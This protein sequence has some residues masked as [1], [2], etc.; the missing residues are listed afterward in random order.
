M[1]IRLTENEIRFFRDNGFV[2]KRKVLRP[3]LI[4]KAQEVFWSHAP[5]QLERDNPAS[6]IGPFREEHHQNEGG[7]MNYRGGFRW[8]LRSI[9]QE[10]W[11]MDLIP[12]D[13]NMIAIAE[14]LLGAGQLQPP[15]RV[16][17]IYSTLPMTGE[18]PVGD[19]MHVDEHP[20]HLGIV[21]YLGTVGPNGG[22]FRVWPTSHRW[23]YPIF[24]SQYKSAR[25]EA[26]NEL[27][28]FFET[29]PT[30]D[31]TG[32]AGDV[33]LWHHRLAHTAGRNYS[34][35]IRQAVLYDFC[36]A[37]IGITQEEPPQKDMWRDWPGCR[38]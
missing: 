18:P 13:A 31:C 21:G 20:F 4:A 9:C 38:I 1:S 29:Q 7:G 10:D 6:W 36:K 30:V 11:I 27:R 32:D 25:T 5:A 2:I 12:R 26:Y 23:F 17:G 24:E 37:D 33:V 16:R 15:K 22:G 34:S 14:Q 35:R 8:N 3:D 19:H 28:A